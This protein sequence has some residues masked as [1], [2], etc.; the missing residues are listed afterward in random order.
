MVRP[1]HAKSF[2]G[3]FR[4][5][6]R[7]KRVPIIRA[8]LSSIDQIRP[9]KIRND[10][11]FPQESILLEDISGLWS[12]SRLFWFLTGFEKTATLPLL[13]PTVCGKSRS[14]KSQ[15][16]RRCLVISLAAGEN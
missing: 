11:P 15:P 8:I 1:V 6:N 12:Q 14:G 16:K 7:A 4:K 9:P 3:Y 2:D 10:G 5:D 13:T